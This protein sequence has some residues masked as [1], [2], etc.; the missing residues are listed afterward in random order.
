M[1]WKNWEREHATS[2]RLGCESQA[3]QDLELRFLLSSD[4]SVWPCKSPTQCRSRGWDEGTVLLP[5]HARS[6]RQGR[7]DP[8]QEDSTQGKKASQ[9]LLTT[10]TIKT[11]PPL[12]P[13]SCA[14]LIL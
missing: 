10:F 3:R 4:G 2:S 8:K 6:S 13:T 1:S 11:E 5:G 12:F 9:N 7:Y 14:H